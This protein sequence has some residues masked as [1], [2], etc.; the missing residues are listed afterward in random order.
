MGDPLSPATRALL[1]AAKSDAP[2]AAA[3]A[4]MWGGVS[5]ATGVA[6]VAAKGGAL[7]GLAVASASS[8]KFLVLGALLGS[9]L[10]AGVGYGVVRQ[11]R[12]D[13]IERSDHANAAQ[14]VMDS[15]R[16]KSLTVG[17]GLL[18][19][20]PG[21][22]RD[23]PVA[24]PMSIDPLGL[25]ATPAAAQKA[26]EEARAKVKS[27][28]AVADAVRRTAVIRA[29]VENPLAREAALI[30]EA[31]GALHRDDPEGALRSLDAARRL[32]SHGMEPEQLAV[33]ARALRK[34]GMDSDAEAV[35]LTLKS[36][37][38]EH[39]LAR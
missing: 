29:G 2:G 19:P 39:Y 23:E 26:T 15:S 17:D 28:A 9:V 24:I 4:Q 3:R 16:S 8:G 34:L 20:G 7:T 22:G 1:Q 21:A 27:E 14:V 13:R 35:E 37:Y 6:V 32:G 10:T 5:T 30:S 36:K 11:I 18:E 38:P 12:N 33:R 25:Y 31:E